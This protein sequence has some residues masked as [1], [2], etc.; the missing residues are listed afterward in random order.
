MGRWGR[1]WGSLQGKKS[2]SPIKWWNRQ[3]DPAG[4]LGRRCLW[5]STAHPR[6]V[7]FLQ[8]L[9][10]HLPAPARI[11]WGDQ[12]CIEPP[13]MNPPGLWA[14]FRGLQGAASRAGGAGCVLGPAFPP[15]PQM[16]S[17]APCDIVMCPCAGG[18]CGSSGVQ[19]V[20]LEPVSPSSFPSAADPCGSK[21]HVRAVPLRLQGWHSSRGWRK[22]AQSW[23]TLG[24][25]P[26]WGC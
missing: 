15:R 10:L 7:G 9:S 11:H 8:S 24:S 1:F 23:A 14:A 2:I 16:T 20:T 19:E 21:F 6:I 4:R 13:T 26:T 5:S 25:V 22:P 18:F 3:W 12:M 17:P